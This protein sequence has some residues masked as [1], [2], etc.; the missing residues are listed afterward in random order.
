MIRK[1]DLYEQ[2]VRDRM[3]KI[4]KMDRDNS[5]VETTEALAG[6]VI[7]DKEIDCLKQKLFMSRK[8]LDSYISFTKK[9]EREKRQSISEKEEL[10][11]KIQWHERRL[12]RFEG[13]NK[14]LKTERAELLNQMYE[15]RGKS[16]T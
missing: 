4:L 6:K 13:E 10:E 11:T 16:T 2:S 3:F 9:M 14:S 15:L 7:S 8:E 5:N 12:T 1:V